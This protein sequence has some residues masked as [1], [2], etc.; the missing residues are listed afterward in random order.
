MGNVGVTPVSNDPSARRQR[1]LRLLT[2]MRLQ[3]A[4]LSLD[5]GTT[6]SRRIG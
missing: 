2:L 1:R 6:R 3:I 5:D 4:I